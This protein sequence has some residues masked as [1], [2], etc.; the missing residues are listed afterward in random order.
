MAPPLLCKDTR[1][2]LADI[3]MCR[4]C[5][6]DPN[7]PSKI[8]DFGME[9]SIVQAHP[10]GT[11][12][13]KSSTAVRTRGCLRV[14]RTCSDHISNSNQWPS[15]A[16]KPTAKPESPTFGRDVW[17]RVRQ[18]TRRALWWRGKR[19]GSWTST[20]NAQV[21]CQACGYWSH[22]T[23]CGVSYTSSINLWKIDDGIGVGMQSSC[24]SSASFCSWIYKEQ[25]PLLTQNKSFQK[26]ISKLNLP[27]S[28]S[29][30]VPWAQQFTLRLSVCREDRP[31]LLT[32]T[33]QE[34][35]CRSTRCQDSNYKL[36]VM[37]DGNSL[38][39]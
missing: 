27:L 25:L 37:E 5:Q 8:C 24:P 29:L 35:S 3:L 31:T 28:S 26:I 39:Q 19:D 13:L 18:K 10:S 12:H 33:S 30:P 16:Q 22:P 38:N 23:S 4:R 11:V 6:L 9:M 15:P 2:H 14:L 20:L 21:P 1:R 17:I 32:D 36:F 34:A 7:C